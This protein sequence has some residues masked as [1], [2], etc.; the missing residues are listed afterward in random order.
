M[1]DWTNANGTVIAL[2]AVTHPD[3]V[4]G[5]EVN[6][7]SWDAV[8]LTLHWCS[9]EAAAN[10]NPGEFYILGNADINGNESSWSELM[11]VGTNTDTGASEVI[12]NESESGPVIE[13]TSTTG[14]TAGNWLYARDVATESNS[15]FRLITEVTTDTSV[16]V[17]QAL[18][19]ALNQ[20]DSDI[21]WTP[22]FAKAIQIDTKTLYGLNV[23]FIHHGATGA[24]GV[25]QVFYSAATDFE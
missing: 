14:F 24:N 17:H 15:G 25:V 19:V 9:I 6:V 12:D 22:G 13:V 10:T 20:A 21:L 3:K 16:E 7:T 18:D 4:D 8:T 5:T 23:H 1:A 2:T 11:R